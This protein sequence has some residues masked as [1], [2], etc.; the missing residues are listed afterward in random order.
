MSIDMSA[1]LFGKKMKNPLIL[2]SGILGVTRASMGEV[3]RNGAGA[4]T[5]KSLSIEPRTGHETPIVV[6]TDAGMLNAVGYSNPGIDEGIK[7]FS[8]WKR[9]EPF[10][11]SIT[12]KNEKEFEVLTKKIESAKKVLNCAAI[13]V[14][15]SCPH[16]PGYGL[17]AGQADPESA[18]KITKA[19]CKETKLP[20]IVKLSPSVPGEV[21]AA[22]LAEKAG[23]AAIN[24]GNTLGPGM[25][26]DLNRKKPVLSFKMG[27]LSGPAIRPVAIRCVYDIYKEIEIP[28]IGTGGVNDG[29]DA[30]EMMLAGASFVG[31]GTALYFRGAD[32]FRIIESEMR[33]WLDE[34][35]YKSVNELIGV[36]HE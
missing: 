28:I 14:A 5:S 24:M 21:E 29:L 33:T 16:T 30:I 7:E 18:G 27:G 31:V 17:M 8:S 15:L 1:E 32:A 12:G 34:R 4:V 10:I 3:A 20:V 19:V 13:E 22:K 11:I 9:E 35:G 26:I 6:E 25:R 36:T 2:A 23:A